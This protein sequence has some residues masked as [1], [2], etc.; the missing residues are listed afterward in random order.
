M[1]TETTTL[2]R[3]GISWYT[4]PG[5][6]LKGEAKKETL[7]ECIARVFD[8]PEIYLHVRGR[9]WKYI[10]PKHLERFILERLLTNGKLT[11]MPRT[12]A[13]RVPTA[14]VQYCNFA[15]K[16]IVFFSARGKYYF[17]TKDEAEAYRV[18]TLTNYFPNKTFKYSLYKI[19]EL[20]GCDHAT[21]IHSSR[22]CR[23]LM[24]TDRT[25]REK[26]LKVIEK[27]NNN[28]LILPE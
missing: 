8:I 17:N 16:Y 25:Y 15:K 28:I 10:Y 4:A 20:T 12:K 22:T 3:T 27:L 23:N 9:Q 18:D 7:D 5:I 1:R 21:V 2:T 24:D 19:A 11:D 26:C 6:S 14:K 13:S